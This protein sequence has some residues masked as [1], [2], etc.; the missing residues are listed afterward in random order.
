MLLR[1]AI[2]RE[3]MEREDIV[4]TLHEEVIG[5]TVI[6][7]GFIKL[8][9]GTSRAYKSPRP[10]GIPDSTILEEYFSTA[11]RWFES[12]AKSLQKTTA[13]TISYRPLHYGSSLELS[14]LIRSQRTCCMG[15]Q[16]N[17][18]YTAWIDAWKIVLVFK[19][20]SC[21]HILI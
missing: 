10:D 17:Q 4:N 3:V 9:V 15:N 12:I 21:L 20:T 1:L 13:H 6:E 11:D 14:I 19:R 7:E 8:A 2:L 16:Q 5:R 18:L